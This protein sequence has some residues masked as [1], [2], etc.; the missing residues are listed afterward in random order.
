MFEALQNFSASSLHDSASGTSL[1]T[2]VA[3]ANK[4][5]PLDFKLEE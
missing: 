1:L 2:L 5:A 3:L 4:L